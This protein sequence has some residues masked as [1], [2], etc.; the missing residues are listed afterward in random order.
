MGGGW[1]A[2]GS[3]YLCRNT[4]GIRAGPI[5]AYGPT[6]RYRPGFYDIMRLPPGVVANENIG[7]PRPW[8]AGRQQ[9]ANSLRPQESDRV[10]PKGRRSKNLNGR[11]CRPLQCRRTNPPQAFS[12]I[13]GRF[14]ARVLAALPFGG[15]SGSIARKL[16]R[17]L[18]HRDRDAL[19]LHPFWKVFRAVPP[20]LWRKPVCYL[21]AKPHCGTRTD[22]TDS[23]RRRRRRSL[24]R[25]HFARE[26]LHRRPAVSALRRLCGA[27]V[28][29]RMCG[30][31]HRQ[32]A[33]PR[34]LAFCRGPKIL[35]RC[36]RARSEATRERSGSKIFSDRWYCP[37][38][39][40]GAYHPS[41]GRCD[42][43]FSCLGRHLRWRGR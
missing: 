23:C 37:D 41:V 2:L 7:S 19:W 1:R 28:L 10:H 32:L 17:R 5:S 31:G 26:T 14:S 15:G 9:S 18:G 30:A 21:A 35:A 20:L 11:S 16:Q 8:N 12:G 29:R 3:A 24:W 36:R 27:A 39:A 34:A 13:H 43:R 25:S 4:S 38:R 33:L 22:G 40:K 42:D 6:I